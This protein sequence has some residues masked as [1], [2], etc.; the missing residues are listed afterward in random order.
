MTNTTILALALTLLI[1]LAACSAAAQSPSVVP[2]GAPTPSLSAPIASFS[3]QRP[4][5]PPSASPVIGEVPEA[6]LETARAELQRLL[7]VDVSGATVVVAE[8]VE[9]NDGSL[10]CP[11]PGMLYTQAIVPG[12]RLVLALDG[13]EYDFRAGRTGGVRLC[14]NQGA[15][16]PRP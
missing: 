13:T 4:D 8:E 5:I 1:A 14:E 9:W 6:L 10:G 7:G 12:Y 11:E 15:P 16:R 2:V 3:A